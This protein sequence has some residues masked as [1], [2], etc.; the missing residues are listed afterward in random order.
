HRRHRRA[1]GARPGR[2]RR[3][4][5]MR[6]AIAGLS[7]ETNTYADPIMGTTSLEDFRVRR[8][9]SILRLSGTRTYVGGMLDACAAI[10]AEVVPTIWAL[11]GPS[12]TI[13]AGAYALIKADLLAAVASELPLDAIVLELH[14]AAVAEG[15]DDVEADLGA[16]L[17]EIVGGT[18]LVA[19]LDLHGNITPAMGELYD[20][21]FGVH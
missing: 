2:H 8:G 9:A 21:L 19:A 14:G 3:C 20:G 13:E 7:H 5:V 17:R 11:A 12:G 10:D 16:A 1:S 4:A 15:V 6:I 18:A